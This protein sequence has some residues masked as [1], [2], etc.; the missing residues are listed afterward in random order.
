[1]E[2]LKLRNK[3]HVISET[4]PRRKHALETSQRK[5]MDQV[6]EKHAKKRREAFSF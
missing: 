1:M 5:L 2:D 6:T 4:T 3:M